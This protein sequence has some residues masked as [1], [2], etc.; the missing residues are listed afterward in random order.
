MTGRERVLAALRGEETDRVPVAAWRHFPGADHTAEEQ[1]ESFTAFQRRFDWDFAKLMF[2]NSFPIEDWGGSVRDLQVP[3]G[4]YLPLKYAVES[5]ADWRKLAVL[6]PHQG[7]LGEML[8]VVRGVCTRLG[9]GTLQLATVFSPLTVARHLGGDERLFAALRGRPAV[10]HAALE[11]IAETVASFSRALL[12]SGADG[13]FFATQLNN[14]DL[15]TPAEYAA[16]G[17]PYNRRVLERIA[18]V[19]RFTL[20]HACGR[21][22]RLE[23]FADY[24]VHALN[25]EDRTAGPSLREARRLT[26]L[27]LVGGMDKDGTL[28]TGTPGEVRAQALEAVREAGARRLIV[29]PGCGL[30]V[31]CPEENLLALRRA[32]EA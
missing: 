26:G 10:L 29:A 18:G 30:P 12:E 11:V 1:V 2:R 14:R 28:R 27:C 6:D 5:E 32:V 7:T 9:A 8:A 15:L 23:E 16:F 22:V 21:Q 19:S 24:P 17:H 13:I 20:L 3:Y 4:W 25:W 31:D